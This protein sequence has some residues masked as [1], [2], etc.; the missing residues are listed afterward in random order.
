LRKSN[1]KWPAL[2]PIELIAVLFTLAVAFF[3]RLGAI[4]L[5]G[6]D[7]PRYAWIAR[8]MA[9]TGDWITPRLYGHP[10]FEKPVLY[11]WLAG[12]NFKFIHS[13]EWAARLP[14]ALAAL[15]TAL[16]LARCAHK[17]FNDR[18]ALY[19][20]LIFPTAVAT[21]SMS[22]AATPD[23]LLT[24]S[25]TL[26]MLCAADFFSASATL[27]AATPQNTN[28]PSTTPALF[29]FGASLA[30]GTLAKGPVAPLLAVG[31]IV[32]WS[33]L[34][35]HF[36]AL[37]IFLRP[38]TLAA[39]FLLATPWYALCALRN[40]D[41]LRVFFLQHN[42]E[43]YLT[44]V[45]RHT[46][47]FWFFAPITLLALLPWSPLLLLLIP[48]ALRF[49]R[50]SSRSESRHSAG[51]FFACWAIFPLLFFSLSQSKLPPYILPSIPPTSLI[52]AAALARALR[53]HCRQ[54]KL[55]L[56]SLGAASAALGLLFLLRTPARLLGADTAPVGHAYAFCL[57]A[58]IGGALVVT[59]ALL[60]KLHASFFI[61]ALTTAALALAALTTILLRLDASLSART[62]ASA[63]AQLN[64]QIFHL[65]RS[66]EFG[67]D[68][69]L[70]RELTE[71]S[72]AQQGAATIV[73][74]P[75]GLEIPRAHRVILRVES[76]QIYIILVE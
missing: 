6:P 60:R 67:L 30:F 66:T 52:L 63:V 75:A 72:P 21:L 12:F 44:P 54:H 55:L 18:A 56:P 70:H 73:A 33:L 17:F 65:N 61:A 22:R 45:F 13:A 31:A 40:P 20:L 26:A 74:G 15:L 43:R 69:Y 38:A 36:R 53:T 9:E 14:S 42:F 76:S 50:P 47:P 58:L 71:W 11:Y 32:L 5:T 62:A 49:T 35:K 34:T 41:F 51:L 27:H 46:Q 57:T 39:F 24:C 19:A 16:A 29:L 1:S 37:L 3:T 59:L 10:W 64:P 4:G 25:L 7:E 2:H 8:A 28:P 23:M 68:F 48:D